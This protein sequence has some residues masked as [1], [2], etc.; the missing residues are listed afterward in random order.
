MTRSE[1]LGLTIA[2]SSTDYLTDMWNGGKC[3]L[4]V[5]TK[6]MAIWHARKDTQMTMCLLRFLP[7]CVIN[8]EFFSHQEIY[9]QGAD[10]TLRDD[11]TENAAY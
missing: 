2:K 9:I 1:T 4:Y 7:N 6:Y 8:L 3:E 11:I 10:D 5:W